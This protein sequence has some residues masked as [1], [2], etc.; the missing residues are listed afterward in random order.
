MKSL[1]SGFPC[2][3]CGYAPRVVKSCFRTLPLF[4]EIGGNYLLGTAVR[5][6]SE[7]TV[8]TALGSD[9]EKVLRVSELFPAD[10]AQRDGS[11]V[12]PIDKSDKAA[13]AASLKEFR[14]RY[15][16]LCR[17]KGLENITH[18]VDFIEENGTEYIVTEFSEGIDLKQYAD[19]S[20]RLF[21]QKQ[22]LALMKPILSAVG[23]MHGKGVCHT[24][25][26]AES[27]VLRKDGSLELTDF[28][29]V[30]KSTATL[31]KKD[32]R[33]LCAVFYQMVS[34]VNP[35][36]SAE[37][38]NKIQ[39]LPLSDT[40]GID[41]TQSFS[42]A[43][44]KGL[45]SE[46]SSVSQLTEA[47]YRDK[48]P[49]V[50][51]SSPAKAAEVKV[52]EPAVKLHEKAEE[53]C[54]YD[55]TDN[56]GATPKSKGFPKWLLAVS[57]VFIVILA[58][59]FLLPR[60]AT[61]EYPP[62]LPEIYGNVQPDGTIWIKN[63]ECRYSWDSPENINL[64]DAESHY[65]TA[66][67]TFLDDGRV[68]IGRLYDNGFRYSEYY[69]SDGKI[70]EYSDSD[71]AQG[72]SDFGNDGLTL[73]VH[74][75]DGT[76]YFLRVIEYDE[77]GKVSS[78][79]YEMYDENGDVVQSITTEYHDDETYSTTSE[80]DNVTIVNRYDRAG[81]LVKTELTAAD[82]DGNTQTYYTDHV[83]EHDENGEIVSSVS[84]TV[85]QNGN[86][87]KSYTD[88]DY[89][90]DEYGNILTGLSYG[91]DGKVSFVNCIYTQY[92]RNKHGI[93]ESTGLTSGTYSPVLPSVPNLTSEDTENPSQS[94]ESSSQP[95]ESV[96]QS[97]ENTFTPDEAGE[98]IISALNSQGVS[99]ILLTNH[100]TISLF[101]SGEYDCAVGI[102]T[103]DDIPQSY[104]AVLPDDNWYLDD[105][106]FYTVL[107]KNTDAMIY[108]TNILLNDGV[109]SSGSNPWNILMTI[110]AP[111]A[112]LEP[113]VHFTVNSDIEEELFIPYLK[114]AEVNRGLIWKIYDSSGNLIKSSKG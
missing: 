93:F 87:S 60:G 108:V 66:S 41:V 83:Y 101:E 65:Y 15:D 69:T 20:G 75:A 71:G 104:C 84:E 50:S 98:A 52:H 25:I 42:E 109:Y 33:D 7:Y 19:I 31:E 114:W 3:R 35:C 94:S 26:D 6:T 56:G 57:M 97:S 1:D 73:S 22:A 82:A 54:C 78:E 12:I 34:G 53:T 8:Y 91:D 100:A 74:N 61:S 38:S 36:G 111:S 80:T 49:T 32:I 46:Y 89:T 62:D 76:P 11:S 72:I 58:A 96:S 68:S 39:P 21:S 16:L 107:T 51:L 59:F 27:I 37:L 30:R 5:Q 113:E 40:A 95:S 81:V 10:I 24:G 103:L 77:Y 48:K 67:Y 17:L 43:L 92:R 45:N 44:Q 102:F 90:T 79:N 47:L 85:D 9:K 110:S 106:S 55:D 14:G 18:A 2:P 29:G 13:F 112:F 63:H 86:T 99:C 88:Y 105:G 23:K 70:L 64:S 4:T 28:Y